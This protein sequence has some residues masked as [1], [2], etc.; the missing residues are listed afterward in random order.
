MAELGAR[1]GLFLAGEDPEAA[2]CEWDEVL[3][4]IPRK[5]CFVGE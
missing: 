3:D 1:L 4:D 2:L 5:D